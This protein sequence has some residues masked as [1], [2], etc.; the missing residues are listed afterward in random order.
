[1]LL[2]LCIFHNFVMYMNII[3]YFMNITLEYSLFAYYTAYC[4]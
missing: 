1:M 3:H 4:N 2:R